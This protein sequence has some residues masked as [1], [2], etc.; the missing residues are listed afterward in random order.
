MRKNI[1][2]INVNERMINTEAVLAESI[3]N[4]A[5]TICGKKIA[6]VPVSLLRIDETYQREPKGNNIQN[7]IKE[8]DINSCDLLDVSYR[9]GKFYIIDGQHRYTAANYIGV[10]NLPCTIRTELTRNQEAIIFAR[11]NR[12]VKKLC[13]YDTYK[14]NIVYG[15]T[16]DPEVKADMIINKVC[17]KYNITVKNI[18]KVSQKETK[19]LRSLS[20]ARRIVKS[21]GENCFEWI[22]KTICNTNW[23]NCSTSYSQD[24]LRTLNNFYIENKDNIDK[25]NDSIKRVMNSNT[26]IQ[27]IARAKADFSEYTVLVGL[28]ICLKKLV[29]QDKIY[30]VKTA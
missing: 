22:I 13:P 18:T 25:Y 21:N 12:N 11:Q 29:E 17:K 2:V 5:V 6:S 15:D 3:I 14:A 10:Q 24:I 19:L 30:T 28:N 4:G 7:L 26:P 23:E 20:E 9:D 1:N 27:L 8:W 16:S